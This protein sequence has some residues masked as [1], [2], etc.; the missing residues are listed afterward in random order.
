MRGSRSTGRHVLH[1]SATE[2]G[3]K[4]CR[5]RKQNCNACAPLNSCPSS[6]WPLAG[7]GESWPAPDACTVW[8]HC[9]AVA[10][11]GE[12]APLLR[13]LPALMRWQCTQLLQWPAKGALCMATRAA[14]T[15]HEI[16]GSQRRG[17]QGGG[18]RRAARRRRSWKRGCRRRRRRRHTHWKAPGTPAGCLQR[19]WGVVS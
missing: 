11:G 13:R 4:A 15:P 8:W 12:R 19:G 7:G 1:L 2:V 10:A 14:H 17:W 9:T 5:W 18:R 3:L 6:T 16:P